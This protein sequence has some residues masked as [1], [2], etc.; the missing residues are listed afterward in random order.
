MRNDITEYLKSELRRRCESPSNKFGIGIY[1][2]IKAVAKNAELLSRQLGANEE[3]TVIAAWLHDIAS[4]TDYD[5][6]E[7]HHIHAMEILSGFDYDEE[8]IK[9]VCD[10]IKNHRGSV[11]FDKSTPEEICVADADAVSHFDSVP[12]LLY[13]AFS[14]KGMSYDEGV[15]FVVNKLKRSYAKLSDKSKVF[16][17]EKYSYVMEF[18]GVV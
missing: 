2:H 9:Q 6:Y 1:D 5:L 3:I 14:V 16:Y 8:K 15:E 7:N 10:C 13:L 4:V 12:S 18:L 11:V 17:K